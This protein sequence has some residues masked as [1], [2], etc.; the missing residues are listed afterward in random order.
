M[1]MDR[2][3]IQEAIKHAREFNIAALAALER[4][5]AEVENRDDL[6]DDRERRGISEPRPPRGPSPH[7]YSYGSKETGALRRK[8]MDL[9][10]KLA[11]LRK[12]S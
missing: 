6:N 5:D 9:T 7:D 2:K 10:R 11:E 1:S 3:T 4:L 12:H 8:S